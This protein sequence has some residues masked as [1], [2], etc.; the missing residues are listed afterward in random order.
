MLKNL[1][2]RTTLSTSAPNWMKIL[3]CASQQVT[4]T[5][6]IHEHHV[7]VATFAV[8]FFRWRQRAKELPWTPFW[9]AVVRLALPVVSRIIMRVVSAGCIRN[10][11]MSYPAGSVFYHINRYCECHSGC[12]V[13]ITRVGHG[14][15]L[16][17]P[18]SVQ[19]L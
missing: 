18:M 12:C 4:Q 8:M 10:M 2:G 13:V 14:I 3:I 17:D 16:T 5:R 1:P 19:L 11:A 15:W 7:S 6:S 9:R